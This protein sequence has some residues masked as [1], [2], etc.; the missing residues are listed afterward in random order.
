MIFSCER[1]RRRQQYCPHYIHTSHVERREDSRP[2]LHTNFETRMEGLRSHAHL[3]DRARRFVHDIYSR[4]THIH[5]RRR[6]RSSGR[7]TLFLPS[8]ITT[9]THTPSCPPNYSPRPTP[10]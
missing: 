8:S 4:G 3:C 1:D 7:Y 6:H 10:G 2:V 9:R 5:G